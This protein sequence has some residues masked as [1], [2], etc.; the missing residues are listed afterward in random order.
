VREML[1]WQAWSEPPAIEG[2]DRP[3]LLARVKQLRNLVSRILNLSK[4][5]LAGFLGV[6]YD[7]KQHIVFGPQSIMVVHKVTDELAGVETARRVRTRIGAKE[8][9]HVE[10]LLIRA[11]NNR[12]FLAKPVEKMPAVSALGGISLQRSTPYRAPG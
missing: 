4:Y 1:F 7:D 9:L 11:I 8:Q 10:A 3:N 5:A 6:Q 12:R 2:I